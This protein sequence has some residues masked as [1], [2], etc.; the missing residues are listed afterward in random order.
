MHAGRRQR[1]DLVGKSA[2]EAAGKGRN[3][4]EGRAGWDDHGSLFFPVRAGLR[5]STARVRGA[6][7]RVGRARAAGRGGR[8]AG[9]HRAPPAP[10]GTYLVP[11]ASSGPISAASPGQRHRPGPG[12]A[13]IPPRGARSR[14]RAAEPPRGTGA[15]GA[16]GGARGL[17]IHRRVT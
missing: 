17:R 3:G 16:A 2:A 15:S 12:L 9:G 5:R 6:A 13:S 4:A 10:P 11:A 1:S 8:T 7:G 14:P